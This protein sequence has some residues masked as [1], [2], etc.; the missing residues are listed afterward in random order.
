MIRTERVEG[1]E[2][3]VRTYSDAGMMITQD[4]TGDMYMEAIDPDYMN[5]T[6]TES[7]IPAEA[8]EELSDTEALNIIMGRDQ[9]EPD[10]SDEVPQAD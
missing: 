6:Y 9:D 7:D 4:G 2:D 5:R 8:E 10:N 3:L 1:S